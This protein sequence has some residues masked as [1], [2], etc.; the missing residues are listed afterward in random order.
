MQ[1]LQHLV[2]PGRCVSLWVSDAVVIFTILFNKSLPFLCCFTSPALSFL[3]GLVHR[4]QGRPR[5]GQAGVR[6]SAG[7]G[8]G[9]GEPES[10]CATSRGS[11]TCHQPSPMAT[12]GASYCHYS[13][14]LKRNTN[15][16]FTC[17]TLSLNLG[18]ALTKRN[19]PTVWAPP[20]TP[21]GQAIRGP[22]LS[23]LSA[24]HRPSLGSGAARP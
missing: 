8:G 15:R 4:L 24:L 13:P 14:S 16:I 1:V 12:P 9:H 23:V 21:A 3:L 7:P 6:M 18:S 10:G 11:L 2:L 17:D 5:G 20:H 22:G 19:K